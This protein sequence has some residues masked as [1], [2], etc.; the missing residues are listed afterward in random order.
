MLRRQHLALPFLLALAA[1]CSDADETTAASNA[2]ADSAT[3]YE[4]YTAGMAKVGDQGV[5]TVAIT[6]A[7]PSPPN[8]GDNTWTLTISDGQGAPLS[9]ASISGVTPFMPDHGHGTSVKPTVEG[10]DDDGQATVSTI[11][12]M[13]PGVWEVS[14]EVT[15]A[16]S[17]TD[18]ATF[19]FCVEG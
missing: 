7:L 19:A 17:Q 2:C 12:L 18:T 4:P 14:V 15:T 6:D 11:D 13:M 16:D 10:P 3:A 5:V 8:R 9:G 1:G